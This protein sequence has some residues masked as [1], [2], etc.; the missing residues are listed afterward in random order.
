MLQKLGVADRVSGKTVLSKGKE[1]V[2]E[3]VARGDVEVGLR[4]ISELRA[5]PGV[6]YV[7]P[8]PANPQK[9]SLI[10]AAIATTHRQKSPLKPFWRFSRRPKARKP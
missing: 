10:S 4:Q 8:L 5:V 2:G 3:A 6:D 7:G 9:N 1:L